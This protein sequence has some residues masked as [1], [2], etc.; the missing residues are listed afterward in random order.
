MQGHRR[1]LL[2]LLGILAIMLVFAATYWLISTTRQSED[3]FLCP[4][5]HAETTRMALKETPAD[6]AGLTATLQG[7]NEANVIRVIAIGLKRKYPDADTADIVNYMM[8]AYCPIVAAKTG[9]SH[10]E[11]RDRMDQFSSQVF[12]IVN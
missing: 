2:G 12:Q 6:M 11:K 3:Q 5:G 1:F 9:L 7:A 4:E 10:A 8:A